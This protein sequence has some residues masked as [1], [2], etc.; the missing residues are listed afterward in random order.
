MLEVICSTCLIIE[1]TAE[2]QER[3]IVP[4]SRL[5]IKHTASTLE[6]WHLDSHMVENQKYCKYLK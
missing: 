1:V 6:S 4:K 3:E 5:K 2:E